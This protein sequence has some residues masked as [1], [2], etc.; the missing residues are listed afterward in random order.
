VW[1]ISWES[2][3]W[4]WRRSTQ[5]GNLGE[6]GGRRRSLT[7]VGLEGG[8]WWDVGVAGWGCIAIG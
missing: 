4:R 6:G 7:T 1:G 3:G 8:W 2:G 5:E